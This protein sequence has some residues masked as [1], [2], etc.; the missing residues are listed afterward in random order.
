MKH[1]EIEGAKYP[2]AFDN[3][4]LHQFGKL[5]KAETYQE[6]FQALAKASELAQGGLSLTNIEAAISLCRIALEAG[7]EE[8]GGEFTLSDRKLHNALMNNPE[9]YAAILEVVVEALP[10]PHKEDQIAAKGEKKK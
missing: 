3:Y 8:S 4:S 1:V 10:K 5:Q 6:I 2:V 7:A 9:M